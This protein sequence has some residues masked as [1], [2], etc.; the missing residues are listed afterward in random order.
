M[1]VSLQSS[2]ACNALA[3]RNGKLQG[4]ARKVG[5]S[6]PSQSQQEQQRGAAGSAQQ[7]LRRAVQQSGRNEDFQ[8]SQDFQGR[9]QGL[10][11]DGE[12][13]GIPSRAGDVGGG[14]GAAEAE[15]DQ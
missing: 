8:D 4:P 2:L 11:R 13:I 9:D 3:F 12:G 7:L 5:L 15:P 6:Q 14:D 10:D 1:S